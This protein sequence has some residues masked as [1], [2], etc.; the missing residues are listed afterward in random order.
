MSKPK[1]TPL[2]QAVIDFVAKREGREWAEKYAELI[3]EPAR[4]VGELE[5]E[6]EPD[7]VREMV[8]K[9]AG[10]GEGDGDEATK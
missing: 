4:S 2:E 10:A 1:Y 8:E 5:D 6:P 3:L 9:H 7:V